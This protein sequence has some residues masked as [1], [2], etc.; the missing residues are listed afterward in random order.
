MRGK[1]EKKALFVIGTLGVGG[2]EQQMVALIEGLCRRGWQCAVFVLD[3][4]G[5]LRSRLEALD[6]PIHSVN[7]FGRRSAIAKVFALQH[8]LLRLT[9]LALGWRPR[10]LQAYLPLTNL[11][12]A[13]AGRLAFVPLIITCRRGLGTHQEQHPYWFALDRVANAL[14]H[15]VTCNSCAVGKD[16]IARDGIRPKKL[17]L[18]RNG[19][20]FSRFDPYFPR[21]AI[22]N[23]LGLRPD[24][25]VI[26]TVGNLIPYKGHADLLDAMAILCRTVWRPLR[27][28]IAGRD[29]GIGKDLR[30]KAMD[31]GL[32]DKVVLLGGRSDV[33]RILAA[34]DIFVLPSHEEGSSNALLEAMAMGLPIVATD[35]GGNAEALERGQFGLLTPARDPPKLATALQ[36][37]LSDMDAA[38][39][40][41]REA[42]RHVRAMYGVE[43]MVD[44]HERLYRGE[45]LGWPAKASAV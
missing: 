3:D 23:E 42:A 9:L 24:A 13:L 20:D 22:R 27:L 10:L 21:A 11:M 43:H 19:H 32:A 30:R 17:A 8:G 45:L 16:T 18:I 5:P 14:S 39:A 40:R 36:T 29:D 15:V 25:L 6:V 41:G 7:F 34:A 38:Q 33:P 4:S 37:V 1:T 35:V 28:C 12:G 26:V 2:A 31:L 44:M